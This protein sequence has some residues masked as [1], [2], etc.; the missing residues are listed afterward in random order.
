MKF[1]RVR[2]FRDHYPEDMMPRKRIF[3]AAEESAEALGFRRVDFPSLEYL[4]L[5]RLKSGDELVGQTFSFTDKG[6]RE[7]TMIPEATPSIVRMITARK[8]LVKPIRWYSIPKIFR[9]E[10][11][12]SG[13]Y[14][15]HYQFNADIFGVD[16]PEADAEIIGLAGTILD[17]LGLERRYEIRVSSRPLLER[18][19][20]SLECRDTKSAFTVI[21]RFRKITEEEFKSEISGTG[22]N[23][24]N[25]QTLFDLISGTLAPKNLETRIVDTLNIN[26]PDEIRRILFVT[27]LASSMINSAIK[28]DLSIVRGL[29]YYTGIVFEAYDI[30]GKHRAI[31][32]G[33]RYDGLAALMSDQDIP[34]VGFGMGDAVIE[35]L[36]KE[37]GKWLYS[38]D[39]PLFYVSCASTGSRKYAFAIAKRIRDAGAITIDDLSGRG[40]SAQLR[41]AA[42][43]KCKFAAIVGERE[44][45]SNTVTFRDLESGEQKEI[46]VSELDDYIEGI[47]HKV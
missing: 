35:I 38:P 5:Y 36:M 39:K 29:A 10:E 27:E 20:Q 8:D 6:G 30:T 34:A 7:V 1:E 41:N 9:Y 2:G 18:I 46:N 15:E 32:G 31:L 19:L 11:P 13:R 12:Q 47:R 40:L 14:R 26:L 28:I 3:S 16:S 25:I 45:N 24:K 4:D 42:A 44:E 33:G 22:M 21:D 43:E 37:E 23:Q 17:K